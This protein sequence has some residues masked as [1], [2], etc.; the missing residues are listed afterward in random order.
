MG[1]L[2]RTL[3][4]RTAGAWIPTA[5][6]C[7]LVGCVGESGDGTAAQRNGRPADTLVIG[8]V[9]DLGNVNELTTYTTSI[10]SHILFRMF[11][12]L[13][14]ESPDFTDNPPTIEPRL[15]ESW[16]WSD[17]RLALTFHLRD[18]VFWTDGVPVTAED[19]RFTW[20]AQTHPDVAWEASYFKRA[21][22]DVEVIDD[23]TVRFHFTHVGP[24]HLLHVNEGV[25]LPKHAWGKLPFSEWRRAGRWFQEN[26][27]T[28]GPFRLE[29]WK[30]GDEI[31]LVKNPDYYEEGLP[32]LD[33][34]V[35]RIVPDQET[36]I[37]Q[38]LSGAVDFG[39]GISPEDAPR[40]RRSDEVELIDFWSITY[41]FV[42]WNQQNP[43]FDDVRV[44]RALTL[45]IDRQTMVDA[46]WGEFAMVA[47]SP[48][49]ST[50]WAHNDDLEPWPFDPQRARELLAEAGWRD[51]DGDGVLERD[52]EPFRFDLLV[53]SGNRQRQDAAVMIQQQLGE[54]G[55]GV[56]LDTLDFS[57]FVT[58][59]TEG[60]Y[61]ACLA[62]LTMSTDLNLRYLLHSDQIDS[63]LNYGHYS[64]P[65]VDRLIDEA[66]RQPEAL[67]MKPYLDRIQQ[68]VHD[69][70]PLT[71][72]WQ[73][74]R[75]SAINRRVRGAEPNL[76]S[77]LY[78]LRE[79]WIEPTPQ[80]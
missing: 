44:R 15:A 48:I 23:H 43:L 11:L 3:R 32:R 9:A 61:D 68:I 13:V 24:A 41:I 55:V 62:G 21:I 64:N 45:A 69:E 22:R 50:V 53:H 18:D 59:I 31:V 20:Q 79:W 10:N 63:G 40:L 66:N 12:H 78:N 38:L 1:R 39:T 17:D 52:G 65:E 26:M 36:L 57:T 77:P 5:L 70:Q 54:I 37:T 47:T 7:V 28:N 2:L 46:L 27:V 6:L 67:D 16:E 75:L 33:R 49:L 74:K 51:A 56:A 34:V 71:F 19:V 42:A 60:S 76:L 25:I 8:S 29:S 4:F 58:F 30:P 80:S 35:V 73:S 14:E 72:L